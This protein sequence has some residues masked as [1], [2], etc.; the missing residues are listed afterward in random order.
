[1]PTGALHSHYWAGPS[2]PAIPPGTGASAAGGYPVW[3]TTVVVGSGFGVTQ[4]IWEMAIEQWRD[5]WSR[6]ASR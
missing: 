5:I 2:T 4:V 6:R 3:Q 1:M